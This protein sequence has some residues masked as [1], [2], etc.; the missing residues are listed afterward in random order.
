MAAD[1]WV[2]TGK[3]CSRSKGHDE[4]VGAA[5]K[6]SAVELVR[7]QKICS[8]PVFGT[9]ADG[10]IEWFEKV[11]GGTSRAAAIRLAVG[12]GPLPDRLA[13]RRVRKRSGRLRT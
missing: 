13:R 8:G 6:A 3:D 12:G 7:C 1:C 9:V 2:C 11:R 4:L 10:R 5:S